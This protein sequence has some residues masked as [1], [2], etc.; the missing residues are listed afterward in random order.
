MAMKNPRSTILAGALGALIVMTMLSAGMGWAAP[1]LISKYYTNL[2]AVSLFFFFGARLIYHS[3]QMS[4]K[5]NWEEL[6][7]VEAELASHGGKDEKSKKER[8]DLLRFSL[9]GLVSPIF[10][11]AFTLTFLAEWGDRSQLATIGLAASTNV[12]G[13]TLGGVLGH[14]IC[15]SVA[16]CGGC[17]FATSLSERMVGLCGGVLFILF[18]AHALLY[19]EE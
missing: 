11:E 17:Y 6:K 4:E 2:A 14:T 3:Y 19:G 16:V 9:A 15:T 12:V 10:I 1:N 5:E 18:G 7:E 8:R 13:V